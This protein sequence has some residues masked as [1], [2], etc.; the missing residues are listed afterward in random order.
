MNWRETAKRNLFVHCFSRDA[1]RDATRVA[2]GLKAYEVV[3][4]APGTW[5]VRTS[6]GIN[7]VLADVRAGLGDDSAARVLIVDATE[8]QWA[9]WPARS[10]AWPELDDLKFRYGWSQVD[11]QGRRMTFER[12]TPVALVSPPPR[13]ARLAH[14]RD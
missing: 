9:S 8:D 2:A 1:A 5:Y 10:E 12:L 3:T 11:P 7:R 14:G 13:T 6:A 4:V